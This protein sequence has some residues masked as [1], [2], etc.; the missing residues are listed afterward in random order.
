MVTLKQLHESLVLYDNNQKYYSDSLNES[1]VKRAIDY[2]RGPSDEETESGPERGEA[3]SILVNYITALNA[4][5]TIF[6]FPSLEK[7][8]GEAQADVQKALKAGKEDRNFYGIKIQKFYRH[9][10]DF[11]KILNQ[12]PTLDNKLKIFL[13]NP[14]VPDDF[15]LD[16]IPDP[17]SIKELI[18]DYFTGDAGMG[19]KL[20]Q[21]ITGSSIFSNQVP[22]LN[23]DQFISD[24]MKQT[25]GEL[26][27]RMANAAGAVK[28]NADQLQ[29]ALNQLE[30]QAAQQA[31]QAQQA[32][33]QAQA[34]QAQ[35]QE[36]QRLQQVASLN[37]D[38]ETVFVEFNK[39]LT[40]LANMTGNQQI[41]TNANIRNEILGM[42]FQNTPYAQ[43][44]E[45]I[46]GKYSRKRQEIPDY[47]SLMQ[48]SGKE[49]RAI[50]AITPEQLAA[51]QAQAVA[52]KQSGTSTPS[53]PA[54]GSQ[55]ESSGVR[56]ELRGGQWKPIPAPAGAAPSAPATP[57]A[58]VEGGVQVQKSKVRSVTESLKRKIYFLKLLSE[59]YRGEQ[60][61]TLEQSGPKIVLAFNKIIAALDSIFTGQNMANDP[62]KKE[63]IFNLIMN[64]RQ[65]FEQI[66]ATIYQQLQGARR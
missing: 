59:V 1:I 34:Q 20:F 42:I 49:R 28:M 56:Y 25:K 46:N 23:L 35:A 5:K 6:P 18:R 10:K 14:S 58:P 47:A 11:L 36:Q 30:M 54:E 38:A 9:M 21:T 8:V 53:A 27:I 55:V 19:S 37:R 17:G 24:F 15:T 51:L 60:D 52:Q 57:A 50:P 2:M 44:K 40:S 29:N 4:T 16:K 33:A 26:K 31:Q 64:Q 39:I 41:T 7:A 3:M 22:Y 63:Y 65:N 45:T 66:Y 48:P 43:I 62:Q 61:P 32:Q 13:T 12:F